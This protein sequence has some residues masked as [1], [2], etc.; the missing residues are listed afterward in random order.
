MAVAILIA[1]IVA[2]TYLSFSVGYIFN[3]ELYRKE[4]PKL[5][6][7]FSLIMIGGPTAIVIGCLILSVHNTWAYSWT[8][9]VTLIGWIAIVKGILF[10]VYPKAIKWF[11]PLLKGKA[12][13]AFMAIPLIVGLIF[14][15]F[16]FLA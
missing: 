16:G 8:S 15:Y 12:L 7:N 3:K 5:A 6:D 13:D 10:L 14:A 4:V 1:K 2:I 11:E 9:L